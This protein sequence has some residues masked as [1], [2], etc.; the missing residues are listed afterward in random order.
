MNDS[1]RGLSSAEAKQRRLE[2]GPNALPPPK[3]AAW[4]RRLLNQFKSA[5]IYLLLLALLVDLATWLYGGA[6]R[7]PV[8]ALAVFGVLALNAALG[9]LQEYRSERALDE[10]AS[11]SAPKAWVL[12]D[13]VFTHLEVSNLVV[14]D[15]VRLEAGDRIPADGLAEAATFIRVD[16][17]LLTG[18]SVPIEKGEGD[19][20]LSGTLLL[21]GSAELR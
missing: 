14:G 15:A 9:L 8:E 19:E 1:S 21:Q 10:L 20:L 13:G 11:L 17:S 16:E 4:W 2:G 7:V 3:R 12:R 18:E 6:T 5:L